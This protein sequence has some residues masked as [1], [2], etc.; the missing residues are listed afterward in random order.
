MIISRTLRAIFLG[1]TLIALMVACV[2]SVFLSEIRR[3]AGSDDQPVE[4]IV[5]QGDSTSQIATRLGAEGLIRQPLLFTL[6]VRMQGLDGQL[7]AGRYLLSESMTMSD[8]IVALQNSRVEEIQITLIEGLRIEEVAQQIGSSGLINVTEQSFL[9]TVRNGEAFKPEHFLL[10]SLPSG[11]GL[12]GYLFPDTYRFAVTATVTEVVQTMLNR[13][14]Q[15]YATFETEVQVSNVSVHQIVTM[16]SIVQREASRSD[17]MPQIA[18]VFWNRL[19]PENQAET[20]GRLGAD[21]TVQYVL[22]QRGNWWPKLDTLSIDEINGITSPYNTRG[23]P[24][25]PP[26]PISSPGLLA[27]RAAARPDA[28][29]NY[30]YFVAS[31]TSAGTHNFATTYVEFQRY[32][33]EYLACSAQ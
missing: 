30:L 3:A 29:S 20:A 8:I 2:G 11:A 4:F 1:V 16:A 13:F 6:L 31:C 7:Q 26:G 19:K 15:Q 25:L 32:E 18:A 22:G 17:E 12:E 5:E 21:P 9:R 27:L 23:N 33:Q 14:D 10:S 28:S 24:G